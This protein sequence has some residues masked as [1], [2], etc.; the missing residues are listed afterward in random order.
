MSMPERWKE[1]IPSDTAQLGR[2]LL[3]EDD[4]YRRIGDEA[5]A[6][7]HYEDFAPLYATT[8]RGAICPI[9]LSLVIIFQFL[10]RL[11]DREA[12]KM[13]VVRLDWK[14]ALHQSMGW[15]GFH[16]SDLCNFRKRLIKHGAERQGFDTVLQ[17][18]KGQGLLR[19][20]D[21]QRSDSTHILGAVERMSRLELVWETLR[22]ALGE[23]C[24]TATEWYNQTVPATIHELY[25]ERKSDWKMSD[26][27]ITA[28]MLKA[29]QDGYWLLAQIDGGAPQEVQGL[30]SV[31]TLR[32]VLKQ[33][34]RVKEEKVE[35]QST[36]IKGKD[37]IVTPHD[38]EVRWSKKRS[39]EWVGFRLEVTETIDE[40]SGIGFITDID[41]VKANEGD[42]EQVAAIHERLA[43]RDL[44]P[45]EHF[46]DQGYTSGVNIAESAEQGTELVG[47]VA[48]DHSGTGEGFRQTDFA[49]DA[50]KKTATCPG[51]R[52]AVHWRTRPAPEAPDDPNRFEIRIVFECEGCPLHDQCTKGKNRSLVINAF[53]PEIL[54][55]RAEQESEAFRTRMKRRAAVAGTI[56]E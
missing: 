11:P 16:Y 29:G 31:A 14:Y 20:H 10:E 6:Y 25:H 34:F 48:L 7:F 32:T 8:G 54:A 40:E 18:T 2:D 55:R 30:P 46:V 35:V 19:K 21:M 39:T 50:E 33:Q 36:P 3:A 44:T 22:L 12:A 9:M 37:I 1:E 45:E 47:P 28:A 24:Q 53:Q 56:S 17:W 51:G 4:P 38:T 49:I 5:S 41:T 42:S 26:E 27:E 52:S 43:E 15:K 23:M 13:A